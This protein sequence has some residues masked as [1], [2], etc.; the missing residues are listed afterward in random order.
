[1]VP[2]YFIGSFLVLVLSNPV[3]KSRKVYQ[4][5]GVQ[6]IGCSTLHPGYSF[7]T[8]VASESLM[9]RVKAESCHRSLKAI[10]HGKMRLL[11]CY[12]KP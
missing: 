7:Y 3:H 9:F 4:A 5:Q 11:N 2:D 6:K 10:S 1:M 8:A 12:P